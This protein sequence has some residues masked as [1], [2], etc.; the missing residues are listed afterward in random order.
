MLYKTVIERMLAY[1]ATVCCLNPPIR[2]KRKLNTIQSQY[3][4][5]LTGAYRTTAN[6]AL[7]VILRIPPLILQLQQEAIVTTIRRLNISLS[8]ILTAL[9][10]GEVEKRETGWAAHPAECP[11]EEQ[12]SLVPGGGV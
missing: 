3:R 2:I 5:A 11:T 7:Q 10:P 12:L 1:G 6:S 9:V 4:L 8:D